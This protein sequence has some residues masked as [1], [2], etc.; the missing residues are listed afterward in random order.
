MSK[1]LDID[2]DSDSDSDDD[3]LF[4]PRAFPK[5]RISNSSVNII[6]AKETIERIASGK[7]IT[8]S[9]NEQTKKVRR[10]RQQIKKKST[11]QEGKTNDIA[12]KYNDPVWID[13]Q[14]RITVEEELKLDVTDKITDLQEIG[15]VKTTKKSKWSKEGFH[16]AILSKHQSAAR[17]L[18]KNKRKR[19]S[20]PPLTVQYIGASW[21]MAMNYDQ[22]PVSRWVPLTNGTDSENE[23]KLQDHIKYNISKL[24]DFK[25]DLV[26]VK[27]EEYAIKK[28]WEKV[29]I[30]QEAEHQRQ[31]EEKETAATASPVMVSQEDPADLS[32]SSD[33]CHD[34]KDVAR[35]TT[36]TETQDSDSDDDNSPDIPSP[37]RRTTKRS[38]L[39]LNDEIEFY[40]VLA[41]N[42]DPTQLLRAAIV[43]I[44]PENTTY[45]LLLSSK[46]MPLPS[47]HLVRRLPDGCWEQ[48]K[49]FSLLTE[50]IQNIAE[51]G[52]KDNIQRFKKVRG[53]I[54]Q[55]SKDFWK[56]QS[57]EEETIT[58][59]NDTHNGD[60]NND[61]NNDNKSAIPR[62][63]RR[64]LRLP[65]RLRGG[66]EN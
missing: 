48:I 14:A 56:N 60:K 51:A 44:R 8:P 12:D 45:P 20:I 33:T 2:S 17:I 16:P 43:G 62:R 28:L 57:E 49:E 30:Q 39:R 18:L 46:T 59:S 3:N 26:A 66:E 29:R 53:K 22:I 58:T 6:A 65:A 13:K 10:R 36:A 5:P 15:W 1:S 11:N 42:G 38:A 24:K 55:A 50:G 9:I 21:K 40:H 37:G 34:N 27:T 47:S 32:S 23:K 19:S 4:G 64:S 41:T 54:N 63:S 25:D 7:P 52:L 35:S 61:K 31:E